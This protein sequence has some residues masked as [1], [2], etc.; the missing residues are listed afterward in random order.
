GLY[1]HDVSADGVATRFKL[2]L[3][4]TVVAQPGTEDLVC[5]AGTRGQQQCRQSQAG[6]HTFH[7]IS[8]AR[9]ISSR[10]PKRVGMREGKVSSRAPYAGA[11]VFLMNSSAAFLRRSSFV[12]RAV[13]IAHTGSRTK[14]SWFCRWFA[15][16]ACSELRPLFPNVARCTWSACLVSAAD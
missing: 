10:L 7:H 12:G 6:T 15:T 1:P 3:Q 8:P 13:F 4:S 9:R 5:E 2:D 11:Q 16:E 14:F